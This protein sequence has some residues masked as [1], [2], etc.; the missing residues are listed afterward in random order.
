MTGRIE[1]RYT[2]S[3]SREGGIFFILPTIA[4][5]KTKDEYGRLF[6]TLNIVWLCFDVCIYLVDKSSLTEGGL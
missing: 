2:H 4:I 3:K 6:I 5:A 1:T